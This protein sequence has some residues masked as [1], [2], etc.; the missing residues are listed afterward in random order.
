MQNLDQDDEDPD[1][2]SQKHIAAARFLRN[3][4]LIN[5]IFSDSLVPDVRSVVTTTRMQVLKRQVA[6]LTMHQKKLEGELQQIE[7]KFD[8][9]K[10]RFLEASNNFQ[11]EMK[12]RC[13]VKPVDNESYQKMVDKAL[14]QIKIEQLR[15][16]QLQEERALKEKELQ[17][18][19]NLRE[20]QLKEEEEKRL[21]EEKARA[22][23]A[24]PLTESVNGPSSS[25]TVLQPNDPDM[26]E[27][28][29]PDPIESDDTE[30]EEEE[31]DKTQPGEGE[32]TSMEVSLDS[33]P[34]I[35]SE[36]QQTEQ[37]SQASVD[38]VIETVA[39]ESQSTVVSVGPVES[40]AVPESVEESLAET[41]PVTVE[42]PIVP[43]GDVVQEPVIQEQPVSVEQ[44][45]ESPVVESAATEEEAPSNIPVDVP[46]SEQ[47]QQAIPETILFPAVQPPPS[48]SE[49]ATTEPMAVEPIQ[50]EVPSPKVPPVPSDTPTA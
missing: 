10:K 32:E 4:R 44:M 12:K 50:P 16:K 40:A 48:D 9:K 43:R 27:D 5:D 22:P 37:T 2:F 28:T 47:V 42:I 6:S 36:S 49:V 20:K 34:I 3:H 18:E 26:D 21:A 13:A 15:D 38:T 33:A 46:R 41:I 19:R 7:E 1:E 24:A 45:H 17:E 35:A 23:V 14:E 39:S 11:E 25:K 8:T 31:S 30:E 29:I